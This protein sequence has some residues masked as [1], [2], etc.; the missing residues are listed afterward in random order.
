MTQEFVRAPC[1]RPRPENEHTMPQRAAAIQ[2][3]PAASRWFGEGHASKWAGIGARGFSSL[4]LRPQ[5]APA[6]RRDL[7]RDQLAVARRDKR[8]A[9]RARLS[10]FRRARLA[11]QGTENIGFTP[12]KGHT[13]SGARKGPPSMLVGSRDRHYSASS[14]QLSFEAPSRR[15]LRRRFG[16][17]SRPEKVAGFGA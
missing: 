14:E 7:A 1:G 15:L 11:A 3:S 16:A 4:L 5:L 2:S 8:I 6:G 12:E 9:S 13:I 10:P 17:H